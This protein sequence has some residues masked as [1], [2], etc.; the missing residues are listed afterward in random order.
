MI[1]L[2]RIAKSYMYLTFVFNCLCIVRAS[3]T[4]NPGTGLT[5]GVTHQ[6]Q[7]E[8]LTV[9]G[10]T[11]DLVVLDSAGSILIQNWH[12]YSKL[13][14]AM[15][16]SAR[17]NSPLDKVDQRRATAL[18]SADQSVNAAVT[19]VNQTPSGVEL[20]LDVGALRKNGRGPYFANRSGTSEIKGAMRRAAVA[21]DSDLAPDEGIDSGCDS[22]IGTDTDDNRKLKT[23][24]NGNSDL[25]TFDLAEEAQ[26]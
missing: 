8:S 11:R 16:T 5:M 3:G 14:K 9:N 25:E 10:A 20:Q 2:K 17:S 22:E 24:K 7:I 19:E 26:A 12:N 21:C 15:S 6:K 18:K 4:I 13:S 1:D 23:I